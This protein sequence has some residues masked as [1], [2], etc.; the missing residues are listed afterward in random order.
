ML[1]IAINTRPPF[2]AHTA[3]IWCIEI[4]QHRLRELAW[5]DFH[6]FERELTAIGDE[7]TF[8]PPT[9]GRGVSASLYWPYLTKKRHRYKEIYAVR[10]NSIRCSNSRTA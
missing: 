8:P 5:V 10:I 9:R 2:A 1:G 4:Q 6:V 7:Q 3:S